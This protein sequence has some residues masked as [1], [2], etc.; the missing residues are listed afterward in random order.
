MSFKKIDFKYFLNSILFFFLLISVSSV[1]SQTSEIEDFSREEFIEKYEVQI[2]KS[3]NFP[4]SNDEMVSIY[5]LHNSAFIES[6]KKK[7]ILDESLQKI[8]R[9]KGA[10]TFQLVESKTNL[11]AD[12]KEEYFLN[13][14]A[15]DNFIVLLLE[16]GREVLKFYQCIYDK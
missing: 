2:L 14:L 7:N 13:K 11:N 8:A 1:S 9:Q 6:T 10:R 16:N 4:P 3:L 15:P 12:K 5:F